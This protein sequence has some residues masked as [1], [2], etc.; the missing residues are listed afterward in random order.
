M[1]VTL[2][3]KTPIGVFYTRRS[4]DVTEETVDDLQDLM[5]KIIGGASND[6]LNYFKM[7]DVYDEARPGKCAK[8]MYFPRQLIQQSTL[9]L[10]V[11]Q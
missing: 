11:E 5:I 2:T 9:S 7:E 10:N 3:L 1:K 8:L 4:D 6:E